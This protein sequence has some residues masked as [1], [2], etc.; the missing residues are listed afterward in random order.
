MDKTR[1]RKYKKQNNKKKVDEEELG[2]A[3][4]LESTPPRIKTNIRMHY[5]IV[6]ISILRSSA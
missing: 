3:E 5:S 1:G 2:R 6:F 4:T